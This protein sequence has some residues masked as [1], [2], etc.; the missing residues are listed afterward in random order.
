MHPDD[1]GKLRA[2]ALISAEVGS[3][4]LDRAKT[5]SPV[6]VLDGTPLSNSIVVRDK[7]DRVYAVA[8]GAQPGAAMNVQ[9]G[10]LGAL[11]E[12][13]SPAVEVKVVAGK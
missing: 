12:T 4:F 9:V 6:I 13:L 1:V 3:L 8:D 2:P 11:P 10:W 7:T 5:A